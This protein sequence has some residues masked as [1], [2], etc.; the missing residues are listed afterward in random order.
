MTGDRVWRQE[1]THYRDLATRLREIARKCRLP[2]PQREL[3]DLAQQYERRAD[4]MD[5]SAAF[6][7]AKFRPSHG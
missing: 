5:R 1:G 7:R 6:I 3:L 4:H 2:Y